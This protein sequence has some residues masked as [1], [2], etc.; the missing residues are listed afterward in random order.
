MAGTKSMLL[1]AIATFVIE[2]IGYMANNMLNKYYPADS[3]NRSA[4]QP[5][6]PKQHKYIK[7]T[8]TK[9]PY[10]STMVIK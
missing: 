4:K 10:F 1:V 5:P 3:S 2:K 8:I 7:K 9:P 6:P